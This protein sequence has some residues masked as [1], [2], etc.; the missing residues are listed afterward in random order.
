MT[1]GWLLD[2]NAPIVINKLGFGYTAEGASA[3]MDELYGS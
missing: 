2:H 1:N 3:R